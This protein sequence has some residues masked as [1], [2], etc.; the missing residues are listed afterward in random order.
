MYDHDW[1][2]LELVRARLA[3]G[4]DPDRLDEDPATTPLHRAAECGSGEV[5]AA[6]AGRARRVDATDADG[7]TPLWLA[8]CHGNRE[9]AAALLAAGADP[10]RQQVGSRSAGRLALTTAMAPLFAELPG[11]VPLTAEELAAQREADRQIDVFREIL[12]EGLSAAFAT[13]LDED[14]AIRR[15]GADPRSC[16]VLQLGPIG[17]EWSML[18]EAP[19]V[20]VTGVDGGCVLIG[21][22]AYD[23]KV[24]RRM[25]AGTTVYA[26]YFNAKGGIYGTLARDRRLRSEE[27]GLSPELGLADDEIWPEGH[28]RHRFWQHGDDG[29]FGAAPLAYACAAAGMRLTD[30]APFTGPPRRWVPMG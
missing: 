9:A 24:L 7:L 19:G 30:P 25:S 4:A 16:P 28:W 13:G 27:M 26:L 11:A 29:L 2:D 15:L 8:V 17:F 23:E 12:T 6:L 5:V 20:A 18:D 10:W 22:A 3:A 14:E 1:R 21:S